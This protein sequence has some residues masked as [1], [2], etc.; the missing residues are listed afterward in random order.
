M[1][2]EINLSDLQRSLDEIKQ[3]LDDGTEYWFA[4]DLMPLLGYKDIDNFNKVIDK[5][6][7]ACISSSIDS[8]EHFRDV[9]RELKRTNQHTE[10]NAKVKDTILSRYACYLIGQNGDPRKKEIGLAQTY[11][12]SQTYKQETLENLSKDGKRLYIRDKILDQN[13]KLTSTAKESGV[14][15]FGEFHDAGY[16]GLY[17][18]SLKDVAKR[19]RIGKDKLLDRAG[20]TE[21]AA[22]LFRITQTDE[23]LKQQLESNKF[24]GHQKAVDTHL[25]VGKKVRKAIKDIGGRMPEN[26]PAEEHIKEVKKRF[27]EAKKE[28]TSKN[29]K[30]K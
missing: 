11:F 16:K 4:R 1:D 22:N 17:G 20:E 28:L 13:K 29:E 5:A 14:S 9:T 19:K 7:E 27:R 25:T 12:A 10:Y 18:L 6:K 8:F 24:V 3:I 21:L 2:S 15:N 23:Q 30:I 26:I